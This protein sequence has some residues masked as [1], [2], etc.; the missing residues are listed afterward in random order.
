MLRKHLELLSGFKRRGQSPLVSSGTATVVLAAA[1]GEAAAH[2][3]RQCRRWAVMA[4]LL[5]LVLLVCLLTLQQPLKGGSVHRLLRE[6]QQARQ[7]EA[8]EEPTDQDM[9]ATDVYITSTSD[10]DRL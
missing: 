9:P 4:S 8:G 6:D 2:L 5:G 1:A 10:D 7:A 3:Q